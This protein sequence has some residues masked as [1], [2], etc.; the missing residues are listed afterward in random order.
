M[1]T[2][3]MAELLRQA[4]GTDPLAALRALVGI[5]AELERR[6]AVLVRRARVRGVSWSAI[7]VVL[8]VSRQAVHRKHGGGWLHDAAARDGAGHA[9][10]RDGVGHA[11]SRDGVG[12][13]G[14]ADDGVANA[15]PADGVANARPA[16]GVAP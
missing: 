13:D 5:R 15:Q 10:S 8:G 11:R 2:S 12:H 9:R 4:D 3:R 16:D 1:T 14:A 7:A 6:E